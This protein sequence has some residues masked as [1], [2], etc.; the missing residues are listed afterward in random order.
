MEGGYG[1][2]VFSLTWLFLGLVR[3]AGFEAYGCWVSDRKEYFF[4]PVTMQSTKL[5]ANVV[6]VKLNG[7]IST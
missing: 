5:D 4:T 6:L 3:A 2:S 1:N 7:K